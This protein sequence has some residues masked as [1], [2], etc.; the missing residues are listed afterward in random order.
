MRLDYDLFFKSLWIFA[1]SCCW[2]WFG[3]Q[4]RLL[5]TLKHIIVFENKKE[6]RVLVI[7]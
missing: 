5:E 2:L 4:E 1:C 7:K 6:T 3:E